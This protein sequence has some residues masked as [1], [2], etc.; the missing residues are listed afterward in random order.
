MFAAMGA[1]S[2][3]LEMMDAMQK[4]SHFIPTYFSGWLWTAWLVLPH[5]TLTN[6]AF[7]DQLAKNGEHV[8]SCK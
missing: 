2:I 5:S 1:H 7:P 6:F 8:G 4:S 3:A